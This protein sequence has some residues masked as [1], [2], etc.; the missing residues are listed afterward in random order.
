MITKEVLVEL[1]GSQFGGDAGST[2]QTEEA[3]QGRYYRKNDSHY[4]IYEERMEGLEEPVTNRMKFRDGTVELSRSGPLRMRMVFQENKKHL[5]GYHTPYGQM[6]LGITTKRLEIVRQQD[7][8]GIDIEYALD[9][10]D[11][12]VSDCRIHIRIRPADRSILF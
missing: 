12:Y 6:L 1:R 5:T 10:N 7:G 9:V 3:M 8:V 11:E 2:A 4:V